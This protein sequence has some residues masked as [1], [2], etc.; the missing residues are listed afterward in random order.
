MREMADQWIIRVLGKEYGPADI[1]TLREWK[2]EGRLLPENEARRVDVDPAP[3]PFGGKGEETPWTTAAE[4]PGLFG[5]EATVSAA[6]RLAEPPAQLQRRSFAQI[7]VETFRVYRRGFVQ[8]LSLT[9]LVVLPSVCGQLATAWLQTAPNMNLDLRSVVAG[10]FGFCMMLLTLLL[11]PIYIAG[12]QILTAE[13]VTG[14]RI[15]FITALN[16]AMKF[17]P[18]VAVLCVFVYG[19]FFLLT[20]FAFG[21][22]TMVLIGASSLFVVSLALALLVL[23]VWMFGRFFINVLFWQQFAVLENA[24]VVESLRESRKLARSGRD[25]PWFRRP[26]W[27]GVFIASIWFAFVL[28]ITLGPESSTLQHYFNEMMTTQDPQALLQKLTASQQA[29]S[30]DIFSF[31]LNLVQRI[32]QPLLG[33]AFVLLYLDSKTRDDQS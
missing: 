12:I 32:L 6:E 16:E 26:L 9:L 24:G 28:A 17:W 29:H 7:L 15:G 22:A 11:W 14:R 4:I 10:A 25:L 30:F 33:I 3:K 5:V 1:E 27:R 20:V 31:S 23:Q 18:R 19:V 8:F 2:T 21:I 13:F